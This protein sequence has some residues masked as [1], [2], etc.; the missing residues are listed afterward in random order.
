M[1]PKPNPQWREKKMTHSETI[2]LLIL[3][4][5]AAIVVCSIDPKTGT[6]TWRQAKVT[7][8]WGAIFFVGWIAIRGFL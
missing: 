5:A 6:I 2:D 4:F 8:C 7:L 1:N 3:I